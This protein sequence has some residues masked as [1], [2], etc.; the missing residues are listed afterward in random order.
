[1]LEGIKYN[2]SDWFQSTFKFSSDVKGITAEI[3]KSLKELKADAELLSGEL[4]NH[5]IQRLTLLS[6]INDLIEDKLDKG[7][8]KEFCSIAILR[9]VSEL[10]DE[11]DTITEG[12]FSKGIG[13]VTA[14]SGSALGGGAIAALKFFSTMRNVSAVYASAGTPISGGALIT[15]T[16][17]ELGGGAVVTGGGGMMGG[18][19]VLGTIFVWTSVATGGVAI[20]TNFY[21]NHK[22]YWKE[23][24]RWNLVTASLDK[25]I[26]KR[27]LL[28]SYDSEVNEPL[29]SL[30]SSLKDP[31]LRNA[32][33][34]EF[35]RDMVNVIL[36][37][38]NVSPSKYISI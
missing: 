17:A 33:S 27:M 11:L 38:S 3:D 36:Q 4:I 25:V 5:S 19:A 35:V 23:I 21:V 37:A 12:E 24:E 20:A 34:T 32:G 28:K 10:T 29:R 9:A 16:L 13:A 15:A 1:M 7:I 18:L 26:S 31:E 14:L 2:I 22:N 8:N 30:I 6:E